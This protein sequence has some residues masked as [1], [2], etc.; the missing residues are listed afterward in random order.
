MGKHKYTLPKVVYKKIFWIVRDYPQNKVRYANCIGKA[1][2]Q[3][4]QPRGTGTSDPTERDA[5][6][7][8][9][10]SREIDPVDKALEKI[11]SEYRKPVLQNCIYGK[12]FPDCASI[13][14]WKVW[15]RRFMYYVAVYYYG[16]EIW[17]NE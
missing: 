10:L 3:D 13:A 4:G 1:A 7:R 8:V 15:K 14:T 12:R 11:P 17:R 2:E 6:I 5:E 9:Q 16:G